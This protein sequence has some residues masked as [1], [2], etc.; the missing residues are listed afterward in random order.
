MVDPDEK[1][2]R[3]CHPDHLWTH[4]K[5]ILARKLNYVCG[6]AGVS[7]PQPGNYIVRPVMN[8]DGMG[9]GARFEYIEK[10]TANIV[11]P[12]HFWCEIFKGRHLSVDYIDEKQYLCI[13]GFRE[14]DAPLWK[15]STWKKVDDQI[16]LPSILKNLP[17]ETI[18][19]EFIGGKLIEAHLRGNPN[20]DDADYDHA[21]PVWNGD[22]TTPPKG[23]RFI[24]KPE[25]KRV[26]FFVPL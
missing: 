6:P 25:Y 10:S 22:N 20:F 2:W 17:Y 14:E 1:I 4:D 13:E 11:E 3:E 9:I 26:G 15:W 5:L 16:P 21:I 7:V 23:M 19:C 12:G 8:I 18:N 24:A